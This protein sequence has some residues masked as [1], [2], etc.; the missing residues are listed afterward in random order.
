MAKTRGRSVSIDGLMAE[1]KAL[2]KRRQEL[3]A[4][5]QDTFTSLMRDRD[6]PWP[7][8]TTR[9]TA[10]RAT[11]SKANRGGVKRRKMSAAARRKIA[12]AQKRRWAAV[13]AKKATKE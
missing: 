3:T 5:I 1:L 2:D 6:A 7:F 8:R 10:K 13:K 11:K 4:T 12:A 9:A